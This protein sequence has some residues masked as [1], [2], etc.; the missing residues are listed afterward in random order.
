MV[1]KRS[2]IFF[3]QSSLTTD[4][5]TPVIVLNHSAKFTFRWA[6]CIYPRLWRHS[7]QFF[8]AT[9]ERCWFYVTS[10][11]SYF[12]S[13]I[14]LQETLCLLQ[15]L[16]WHSLK[17]DNK[18]NELYI[19]EKAQDCIVETLPFTIPFILTSWTSLAG[20]LTAIRTFRRIANQCFKR[21]HIVRVCPSVMYDQLLLGSLFAMV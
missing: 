9:F 13:A 17:K 6:G 21:F 2:N 7:S 3:Y 12:F 5:Y 11:Y 15:C 8:L 18:G 16:T 10:S 1:L 20:W 14:K 4:G 19:Y